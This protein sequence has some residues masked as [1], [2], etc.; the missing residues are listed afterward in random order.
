MFLC[1][2]AWNLLRQTP[3]Y[4]HYLKYTTIV[5]EDNLTFNDVGIVE[6]DDVYE[7]TQSNVG[8]VGFKKMDFDVVC[9]LYGSL[10]F[11]SENRGKDQFVV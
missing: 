5:A 3:V 9:R 6:I 10:C 7:K 1:E 8:E 11:R 2:L 4:T